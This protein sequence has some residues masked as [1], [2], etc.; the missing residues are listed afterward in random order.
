[1]VVTNEGLGV[2]AGGLPVYLCRSVGY[3]NS[4]VGPLPVD[5]GCSVSVLPIAANRAWIDLP[6]SRELLLMSGSERAWRRIS[7]ASTSIVRPLAFALSLRP[8]STP[9]SRLR[10]T[11]FLPKS[12][13]RGIPQVRHCVQCDQVML[14][15][16]L[17]FRLQPPYPQLQLVL[18]AGG[19]DHRWQQ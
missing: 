11:M 10:M 16:H 1:M 3:S 4:L 18:N 14:S 5:I 12:P 7:S 6:R 8:R 13:S 17:S 19:K 2:R 15:G 9:A